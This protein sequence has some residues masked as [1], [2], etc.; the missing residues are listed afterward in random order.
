MEGGVYITGDLPSS[1]MARFIGFAV[2]VFLLAACMAYLEFVPSR[3]PLTTSP[4]R[5]MPRVPRC[6]ELQAGM[7]RIGD[8][9][10]QFDVPLRDFSDFHETCGDA[11]PFAC[12]YSL[13]PKSG[14][15]VLDISWG[16]SEAMKVGHVPIDPALT[17]SVPLE[18]RWIT[19]DMG[20]AVGEDS[21]G[22]GDSGRRWRRVG[23]RGWVTA[24]Y[25]SISNTDIP[26]YREVP[27]RDAALFDDV[28]S[29]ACRLSG[30]KP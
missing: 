10:F 24:A 3:K 27:E 14:T 5:A 11:P 15:S 19:D 20:N 7:K 28:I 25:G 13:K 23:L 17:D 1:A 2:I 18:K 9:G 30:G 22:N 16:S 4:P 6:G 26:G 29:S 21:F 8:Y 12:G